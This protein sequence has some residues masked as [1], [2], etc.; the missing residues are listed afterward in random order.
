M[1]NTKTVSVVMATY[2]GSKYISDQIKSL[3]NQSLAPIEIIVSDDRSTDNTLE[4]VEAF[5]VTYK[6]DIKIITNDTRLGFRDNFLRASLEARGDFIAFCDQDDIW[7]VNKLEKCSAY[8]DDR[9]ISLIAHSATTIDGSSQVIGEF[10]Q[11]INKT[12]IKSPMSYDIWSTFWGFSLVFRRELLYITSA[13][14]RFIDYISPGHMIAHDRWVCFLGQMVGAT[15]EIDDCLVEYRQHQNNAFGQGTRGMF[16]TTSD[17]KTRS[18]NYIDATS[19]MLEIVRNLPTE[20][21]IDFPLY[22]SSKCIDFV[23]RSLA[24]LHSRHKVY[25]GQS[26]LASL[27]HICTGVIQGK[28]RGIHDNKIRWKSL[29]RDLE[30]AASRT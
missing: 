14:D 22:D 23:E 4:I 28:Y 1:T 2:N 19:R 18:L 12:K 29:V 3:M 17:I 8:F 13:K 27:R 15:A 7:K 16:T 9:N 24:Q 6:T 21:S 20:T 25:L 30:F 26:G 5:K 11:G 10:R